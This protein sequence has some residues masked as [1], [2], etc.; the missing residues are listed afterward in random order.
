MSVRKSQ[1]T[2]RLAR[3]PGV[4]CNNLSNKGSWVYLHWTL[5]TQ[6]CSTIREVI[7]TALY[8]KHWR[9]SPVGTIALYFCWPWA[10]A[11]R[12]L[13]K[14]LYKNIPSSGLRSKH[15]FQWTTGG[16]WFSTGRQLIRV[17]KH[18]T[19]LLLL[20]CFQSLPVVPGYIFLFLTY[21]YVNHIILLVIN[22]YEKKHCC[23]S[24]FHLLE[25]FTKT[26]FVANYIYK[27]TFVAYH[28]FISQL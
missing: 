14:V 2:S 5:A 27:N 22:I 11:R 7:T 24:N 26:K 19:A 13:V 25:I 15:A 18:I 6:C 8:C 1:T 4:Y 21:I 20:A 10:T 17:Y 23:I 3:F 9:Y 12:L 28:I 16:W